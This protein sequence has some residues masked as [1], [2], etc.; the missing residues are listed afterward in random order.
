MSKRRASKQTKDYHNW[1]RVLSRKKLLLVKGTMPVL[2]LLMKLRL[3]RLEALH[4]YHA[5]AH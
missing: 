2:I 4:F 1:F 5:S 3:G